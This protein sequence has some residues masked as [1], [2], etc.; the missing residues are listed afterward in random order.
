MSVLESA[1]RL[2]DDLENPLLVRLVDVFMRMPEGDREV[3]IGAI[4]REVRTR[5]VSAEVAE[6]LTQVELRPNPNARLYLR[7]VEPQNDSDPVEKMAFL[8]AAYSLQRGIDALDPSWRTMVV[9]AL[10]QMDP[11]ARAQL[12][13]FNSAMRDL[14]DEATRGAAAETDPPASTVRP[15]AKDASSTRK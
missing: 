5:L 2:V 8:R 10:R 3:L 13:E 9:T 1:R 7:V 11:A 15:P 12:E 14:L 4:E 6:T